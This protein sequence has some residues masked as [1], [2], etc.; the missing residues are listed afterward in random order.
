[1]TDSTGAV[2]HT[3]TWTSH[4]ARVDGLLLIGAAAPTP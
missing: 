1:V 3:D 4:Y 2:I